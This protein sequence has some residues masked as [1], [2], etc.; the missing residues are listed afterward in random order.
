MLHFTP[1]SQSEKFAEHLGAFSFGNSITHDF[2]AARGSFVLLRPFLLKRVN[3]MTTIFWAGDSTV[4]QNSIATYPQTGIGQVFDRYVKRYQVQIENYAENG[5]S[6][7]Q[8]IDEG[9]LATIYDRIHA[10]DFL[11]VQFG[12]NDEKASDPARYTDPETDFPANLERFVNVARNKGATPVFITPLTRYDRNAP[13]A[14]FH[15]DRWAESMRRTAEKLHV[16][17]IDLTAMSEKLVDEQG[18]AAQTAY[19]MNLPAGI[20]PHFP[21]GQHDNTHLQPAG[22]LAFGGLIAK[23]LHDLGGAYAALLCDEY[24]QWEKEAAQ[25]GQ[26][27]TSAAEDVE[28]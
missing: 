9:R 1:G 3:D 16:A 14:Q 21:L 6:T 11:F 2:L 5:R 7:K 18:E 20:Y 4:K 15:H 12:H 17:L 25:F 8:F 22:A 27:A 24:A 13:G 26:I 10:G 28:A 23:G 19:Y